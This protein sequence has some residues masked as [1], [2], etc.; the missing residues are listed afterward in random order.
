MKKP[1]AA[2]FVAMAGLTSTALALAQWHNSPQFDRDMR[3]C[4]RPG[5]NFERCMWQRGW[6]RGNG[7]RWNRVPHQQPGWNQ[8]PHW[9]QPGWNQP[10][11]RRNQPRLS[12][13][14]QRALDN[15]WLL[16]PSE[17]ARCRATVM[18]TVR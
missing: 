15:C 8:Q 1:I 7:Q 18:S 6:Q 9:N 5:V 2:L 13:M 12:D 4:N 17:Q 10:P 11:P 3:S 16:H 14:Q